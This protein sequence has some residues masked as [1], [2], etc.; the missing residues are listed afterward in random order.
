VDEST[1]HKDAACLAVCV[2]VC[3]SNFVVTELLEL[4]PLRGA[5]AGEYIF[6]REFTRDTMIL[7]LTEV[8]CFVTDGR[9]CCAEY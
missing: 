8:V 7:P 4:I 5:A 2:C 9:S 3:K 6:V 1:W